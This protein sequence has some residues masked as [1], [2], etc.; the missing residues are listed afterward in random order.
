[1]IFDYNGNTYT[2]Q[3]YNE[4]DW[5]TLPKRKTYSNTEFLDIGCAFDIETSKIPGEKLS[6]MYVWQFALNDITII[7]RTWDEFEEFIQR[8]STWYKLDDKHHLLCLVHNFPFEF[9]WIKRRLKWHVDKYKNTDVFALDKRQVIRAVSNNF[10][11]FRDT[12]IL[13][14]MSLEKLAKNYDVGIKKLKEDG[15]DYDVLRFS[16]TQL[17]DL[18]LAYCINDVQILQRFY[19][20]YIKKEFIEKHLK[21]PMTSTGIVRDELNRN[22]KRIPKK[23]KNKLLRELKR[24]FPTQEEYEVM[25]KWLYRGGFVHANRFLANEIWEG[26]DLWSFDL[27]SS[28]PASLLHELYPWQFS[29][30]EPE[31]FYN[32]GFDEKIC[33]EV[34][35]YGTFVFHNIRAKTHHSLESESKIYYYSPDAVFD[36]GRLVSASEII[37]VLNEIDMMCYRKMYSWGVNSSI[38]EI[39][40]RSVARS[41]KKPLPNYVKDL[42]L[43]YF[44][45]KESMEDGYERNLV[46][47]KLN[48]IYG[49]M[50]TALFHTL[51]YYNE[52]KGVMMEKD[53]KQSYLKL[54]SKQILLPQWGIWCTSYSRYN[55]IDQVSKVPAND[56]YN[57]TDS[58]K[59]INLEGVKWSI[60]AF[61]DKMHRINKTMYVGKYERKYFTDL[62][63]LMNEG[64]IVRF[65]TLGAKRYLYTTIEQDKETKMYHLVNHTTVA[66]MKKGALQK[67]AEKHHMD[68]YDAFDRRLV[69]DAE[70]SEKLTTAYCDSEFTREIEGRTI[71]EMSCVTLYQIPFNMKVIPEYLALINKTKEEDKRKYGR[72]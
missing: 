52:E 10:I 50:V 16:D 1:M 64:K 51:F 19:H 17:T 59:I 46:K 38:E 44:C 72:G 45:L 28:Y 48:A 6:F 13:T 68:I 70:E 54:I 7:G 30:R 5:S 4:L 71:N 42:V 57:D 21:V 20:K 27:K 3:K 18:E 62:G 11:E 14:Q 12:Y 15:F 49:M 53:K 32:Y 26:I 9:Q 25:I 58:L 60:D 56:I 55:I 39:E 2:Y 40:C 69:L 61:N 67:Y 65:K 34:A 36:N 47:Y 22:F 33:H 37:V 31:W 41:I 63:C 24:A 66:G 8:L 35:Y 29:E 43:K 23:E